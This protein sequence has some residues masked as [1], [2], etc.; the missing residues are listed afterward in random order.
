MIRKTY[1]AITASVLFLMGL[2]GVFAQSAP[3]RN[4]GDPSTST[5]FNSLEEVL[6]YASGQSISLQNNAVR[7]DQARK[8]KLAAVLG[9]IDVNGSLLSAQFTDHTKLGVNLFPAE[10]FGGEPGTFKEVQMGV[11]YNTNLTNYADIKLINPVGWSN[12]KL[13][14]INIDLTQSNN[15]LTLKSLQENIAANYYNIV[16]LQEQITSSRKNLT[17]AD[18]LLQVAQNKLEEGLVSQQD[19]NES[20]INYLNTQENIAQ[21]S[22][23]LDQYYIS[24]KLL[25]DI[26]ENE[27]IEIRPFSTNTQAIIPPIVRRSEANLNNALLREEYARANYQSTKAAFL[28]SVSI[29]LSNANNLYNTEFQPLSGDWI[30]SNYVGINLNIPIPGSQ[31]ISQKYH[32]QYEYQ[33]AKNNT[34]QAR[35]QTDLDQQSLQSAYEKAVSQTQTD[36]KILS[37]KEDIFDKNQN[38]FREGIISLDVVLNSF[39]AMVN[40]QYKLIASQVDVQLALSKI[41]IHNNIK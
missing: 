37:L 9:T 17:V 30:N 40:A 15:Q 36:K 2:S 22:Y 6:E 10:I 16:L 28:P 23:L 19:V 21:L 29:Q 13:S 34:E 12:L 35:I 25:C 39:N 41:N 5:V 32:A 4:L 1:I 7:M 18:T 3:G 33:L 27:V 24:L 20:N 26:P 14:K 11:R 38:L 8:A 31:R